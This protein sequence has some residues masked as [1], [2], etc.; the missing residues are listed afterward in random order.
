[1]VYQPPT[2]ARDLLPLDVAQKRWIEKR[3][4]EVFHRWGY[5]RIITSTLERLDTLMAGGAIDR[6]AILTVQGMDDENLGLRPELTASIARTAVNRMAVSRFPQRLYYSANVFCRP[7]PEA[8]SSQQEFYQT[9]VELLGGGGSLADAEI[10]SLLIDCLANVGLGDGQN[11]QWQVIVGEAALTRSLL[12]VFPENRRGRVRHAIANLDRMTL[13]T[14]DLA[15]ELRDRA[16]QLLDLRGQPEAVLQ[17]ISQW[18]LDDPQRQR[19]AQL[20]VLFELMQATIGADVKLPIVLDLSLIRTF[21]YYTG[22]V[23]EVANTQ[24]AV[25]QV[26]AQGGRYDELLGS[27]HPQGESVPGIGFSFQIDQLYPVLRSTNQLP[28]SIPHNDCLV[29]ATTAQTQ[30]AALRHAQEL[31]SAHPEWRVELYLDP[32]AD[33][34]HQTIVAY[35]KTRN[36]PE[37]AWVSAEGITVEAVNP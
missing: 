30:A 29:V 19:V 11:P 7:D 27:Y 1:M 17:R 32:A 24:G 4:Q 34:D 16:L 5:H 9:G 37:I 33:L 12:S 15:P 21:D 25:Q 14:L 31:R 13:E 6:S 36:M 35:A 10:L 22:I 3:L 18:D 2:G 26:L 23:F 28:Q 20:Q 8:H